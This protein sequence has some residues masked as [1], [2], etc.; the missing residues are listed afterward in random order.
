MCCGRCDAEPGQGVGDRALGDGDQIG[1]DLAAEPVPAIEGD[2]GERC[3]DEQRHCGLV[4]VLVGRRLVVVV[5]GLGDLGR[6]QC[7]A[8]GA[9]RLGMK[10]LSERPADMQPGV[11]EIGRLPVAAK[12]AVAGFGYLRGLFR[13]RLLL[14]LGRRLLLALGRR[15]AGTPRRRRRLAPGLAPS[16]CLTRSRLK[17]GRCG[18]VQLLLAERLDVLEQDRARCGDDHRLVAALDRVHAEDVARL[19]QGIDAV[20][21]VFG[22]DVGLILGVDRPHIEPDELEVLHPHA[23]LDDRVD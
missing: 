8:R 1:L 11:D 20:L 3:S 17:L 10:E 6:R 2:I 13:R 16:F 12:R 9:R 23:V 4:V 18:R 19:V 5:F 15:L 21:D 14:A 7:L 22:Q